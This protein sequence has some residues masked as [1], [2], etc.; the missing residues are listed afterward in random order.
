M[1]SEESITASQK[2]YTTTLLQQW[3][4]IQCAVQQSHV[5]I[6]DGKI[7]LPVISL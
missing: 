1:P 6:Q 2:I 3:H 7:F 4:A 5:S